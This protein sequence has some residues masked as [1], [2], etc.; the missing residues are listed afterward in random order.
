MG[1][2]R[3]LAHNHLGKPFWK[4]HSYQGR[5]VAAAEEAS[6]PRKSLTRSPPLITRQ[7]LLTWPLG[8]LDFSGW[9]ILRLPLSPHL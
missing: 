9:V 8:K 6:E 2:D 4:V 1:T 5:Q 7:P 3:E